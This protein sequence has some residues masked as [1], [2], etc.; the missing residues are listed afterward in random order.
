[1]I[2][3]I[4][5][6]KSDLKEVSNDKIAELHLSFRESKDGNKVITKCQHY[7]ELF[8]EK[9]ITKVRLFNDEEVESTTYPYPTYSGSSL[10]ELLSSSEWSGDEEVESASYTPVGK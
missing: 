6:P 9:I 8:P 4:V 2:D 5:F 10:D 1:M 7:V 3:Y